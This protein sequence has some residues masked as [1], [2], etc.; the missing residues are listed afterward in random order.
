M[1]EN[2]I[3][4]GFVGCG[5]ISLVHVE[6][7]KSIP[8]IELVAACDPQASARERLVQTAAKLGSLRM[9]A[10]MESMLMKEELDALAI[11]T[12]HA[13]H[14]SAIKEALALGMHVLVEKPMVSSVD[15][16]NE[17]MRLQSRAGKVIVV[18]YQRHYLPQYCFMRNAIEAGE[19]GDILFIEAYQ[20]QAWLDAQ[21]K[22]QNS[23]RLDPLV[24]GGGQL[25]DSGSHLLD[26]ILW[27]TRLDVQQ[28][29]AFG[30]KCGQKVDINSGVLFRG[31]RG[32]IGS[33]SVIG[34]DTHFRE[35]LTIVGTKGSLYYPFGGQITICHRDEKPQIVTE[36]PEGST[37]DADF[38]EAIIHG[39]QPASTP[40]HALRT[41]RFTEAIW[42]SQSK[43]EPV[44]LEV[45]QNTA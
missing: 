18:A 32:E 6:R 40:A 14:F 9:Y 1:P 15:E 19:I 33:L 2:H 29:Y 22:K 28:V 17:A 36:L 13:M 24:S 5:N 16:A 43:G 7:L 35:H 42:L 31:S 39:R 10:D 25:N 3:R 4:L 11:L 26:I 23:W 34:H 20:G 27:V 8:D 37:P 21:F 45:A 30:Q 38:A 44:N 12:P 41:M